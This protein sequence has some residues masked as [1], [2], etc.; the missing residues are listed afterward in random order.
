MQVP[1]RGDIGG[2]IGI[3]ETQDFKVH[4]G[5]ARLLNG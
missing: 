5:G 3:D 4:L 2:F 1:T